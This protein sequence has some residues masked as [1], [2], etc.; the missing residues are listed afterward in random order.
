M[1]DLEVEYGSTP[2]L[3]ADMVRSQL[4]LLVHDEVF[5]SSKRS[6]AFLRYVVEQ[7]LR[8]SADQIKER[9]IGVEVFERDPSYDTNSDHIVRTAAVELRKRLAT[10]YV[11]GRHRHELR[12]WLLPGSYIPRFTLP[13]QVTEHGDGGGLDIQVE[14]A[15]HLQ[16]SPQPER[17]KKHR[18]AYLW[19][20]VAAL[21]SLAALA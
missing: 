7:T 2:E 11:D 6:V 10:Y 16:I 17:R 14:H 12:M 9:T 21:L 19:T 8:G 20:G 15:A 4:E 5:K 1:I 13:G 18:L 3:T